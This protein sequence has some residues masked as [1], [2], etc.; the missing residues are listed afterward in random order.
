MKSLAKIIRE[1]C[2]TATIAV[3]RANF[4]VHLKGLE[5]IPPDSKLLVVANHASYLDVFVIG[6]ALRKN[7]IDIRWVISTANY[8]VKALRWF[9]WIYQV[10]QAANGAVDK[11]KKTL[12]E[13]HWVMIFPEGA[14]R[15]AAVKKNEISKKPGKGTA[16]VALSTGVTILPIGISGADR[17]LDPIS[18]KMSQR[19]HITVRIGKPFKYEVVHQE[20]IPDALLEEKTAEILSRIHALT[21]PEIDVQESPEFNKP[22]LKFGRSLESMRGNLK[23]AVTH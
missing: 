14:C 8:E 19:E 17:A 3:L 12:S 10:I 13:G 16:V 1:L 15:W 5:N 21:G 22:I 6:M 7:L 23:P 18:L 11:I 4:K 2:F 9:Y 20:K